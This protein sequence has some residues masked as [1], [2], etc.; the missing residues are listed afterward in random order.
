[1]KYIK[2]ITF[3][4]GLLDFTVFGKNIF[5]NPLYSNKRIK[6]IPPSLKKENADVIALQECFSNNY[7][8]YIINKLKDDYPYSVN[9]NT[10]SLIKLSNGLVFL[11]KYPIISSEF[12]EY[13]T[14]S[15]LETVFST[16]GYLKCTINFPT[17]GP[18]HFINLHTTSLGDPPTN[19][20]TN[21]VTNPSTNPSTNPV[22]NPSTNP[23]TNPSTNPVT[24][25]STNPVTNP[26]TN[27]NN[28]NSIL[29]NQIKEIFLN[30]DENTIVLGDFNC[31]P[32]SCPTEYDYI[33]NNYN[34]VDTIGSLNEFKNLNLY[35][36]CPSSFLTKN[37]VHS[38]YPR[39]RID[40]IMV[41]KN[42]FKRCKISNGKIL[43]D[44]E[45]VPIDKNNNSTLSD[46]FGIYIELKFNN[47]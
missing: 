13:S 11:S 35:T 28:E 3:N 14:N 27:N 37:G 16:K 9:Y 36:W 26:V 42:L 29:T 46:H 24:N 12:K 4:C 21:P 17:I 22:T 34:F 44:K 40:H 10:E 33:I 7:T 2:I 45:I 1:M 41:H 38:H 18:L 43:F 5:S 30:S 20:S 47:T 6:Y 39:C 25:P 8:N 15:I 31:G 19:P 32:T 23:V